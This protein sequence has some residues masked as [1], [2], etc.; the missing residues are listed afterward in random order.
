MGVGG[1]DLKKHRRAPHKKQTAQV[2]TFIFAGHETAIAMSWAIYVLS[3]RPGACGSRVALS[4]RI[5]RSDVRR[6][7]VS[8]GGAVRAVCDISKRDLCG[9]GEGRR[10]EE[11]GP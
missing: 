3:Q 7:T 2:L 11:R 1:G 9:V 10:G 6:S 4:P 8:A 5:D